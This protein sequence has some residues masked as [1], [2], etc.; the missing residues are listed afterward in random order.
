MVP[1]KA[2]T[3]HAY[4]LSLL[5]VLQFVA[6]VAH[7]QDNLIIN[8]NVASFSDEYTYYTFAEPLKLL[9]ENLRNAIQYMLYNRHVTTI[10]SQD[11]DAYYAPLI[12]SVTTSLQAEYSAP[13]VAKGNAPPV[14]IAVAEP[15]EATYFY[16]VGEGQSPGQLLTFITPTATATLSEPSATA[17]LT[18][19]V[20][21]PTL[22]Y[23]YIASPFNTLQQTISSIL[24]EAV[25]GTKEGEGFFEYTVGFIAELEISL[26]RVDLG[27]VPICYY[28]A[29]VDVNDVYTSPAD[30]VS[31]LG[32]RASTL[33]AQIASVIANG[34]SGSIA[35]LAKGIADKAWSIV[36]SVVSNAKSTA[37]SEARREACSDAR[38][39][40]PAGA[41]IVSENPSG[42]SD[43]TTSKTYNDVLEEAEGLVAGFIGRAADVLAERIVSKLRSMDDTAVAVNITVSVSASVEGDTAASAEYTFSLVFLRVYTP[44]PNTLLT[45]N[46]IDNLK[47]S[48]GARAAVRGEKDHYT[49]IVL[50]L[51]SPISIDKLYDVLRNPDPS[52]GVLAFN[53]ASKFAAILAYRAGLAG[54]P[55]FP[56]C[57][58]DA[59]YTHI[60]GGL[61]EIRNVLEK[62]FV[63]EQRASDT[64]QIIYD[65]GEL[66]RVVRYVNVT[67]LAW[68]ISV[69][70]PNTLEGIAIKASSDA[71]TLLGM[72]PTTPTID[73][74]IVTR[75]YRKYTLSSSVGESGETKQTPYRMIYDVYTTEVTLNSIEEVTKT[76]NTGEYTSLKIK[77]SGS[78]VTVTYENT[79]APQIIDALKT[80]ASPFTKIITGIAKYIIAPVIAPL[81]TIFNILKTSDAFTSLLAA[82]E[83]TSTSSSDT[84]S[85]TLEQLATQLLTNL[86]VEKVEGDGP[87]YYISFR[88]EGS[89]L[90]PPLVAAGAVQNLARILVNNSIVGVLVGPG[91]SAFYYEATRGSTT[92]SS[93]SLDAYRESGVI[94]VGYE[95]W[96]SYTCTVTYE[97]RVGNETETGSVTGYGSSR[98]SGSVSIDIG[99]SA[100]PS[101]LN[102]LEGRLAEAHMIAYKPSYQVDA[103][104]LRV[105]LTFKPTALAQADYDAIYGLTVGWL[106][107]K[108]VYVGP[109]PIAGSGF[110]GYL[111]G[112]I[113]DLGGPS[114][115]NVQDIST[116]VMN[117]LSYLGLPG[118]AAFT[119]PPTMLR[120]GDTDYVLALRG[121]YIGAML[122]EGYRYYAWLYGLTECGFI[123]IAPPQVAV[124]LERVTF[125]C[126]GCLRVEYDPG[127]GLVVYRDAS[128]KQ[129]SLFI[130]TGA[131]KTL[132]VAI[133]TVPPRPVSISLG[134]VAEQQQSSGVSVNTDSESLA[135][136]A[137]SLISNFVGELVEEGLVP[138]VNALAYFAVYRDPATGQLRLALPGSLPSSSFIELKWSGKPQ[139]FV[140]WEPGS[141]EVD[142]MRVAV[143]VRIAPPV[144]YVLPVW[145]PDN[146]VAEVK[147]EV[148]EPGEVKPV[149]LA[150]HVDPATRTLILDQAAVVVH[151]SGDVEY[152]GFLVGRGGYALPGSVASLL[153]QVTHYRVA[154]Y[155]PRTGRVLGVG[156]ELTAAGI[157]K[158]LWVKLDELEPG[159][160]YTALV[161]DAGVYSV[162]TSP[163]CTLYIYKPVFKTWS[164]GRGEY[165]VQVLYT[166]GGDPAYSVARVGPELRTELL[167]SLWQ[168][169][170][171][172]RSTMLHELLSKYSEDIAEKVGELVSTSLLPEDVKK[173]LEASGVTLSIDQEAIRDA[174]VE[175][176]NSGTT[177]NP[178]LKEVDARS[179]AKALYVGD[180]A[181]AF[182][183][184][185][186][187]EC[188]DVNLAD[189]VLD[190]VNV[191]TS[192]LASSISEAAKSMAVSLAADLAKEALS[193]ILPGAGCAA[194]LVVKTAITY[195]ESVK[196]EYGGTPSDFLVRAVVEAG[197]EA[198]KAAAADTACI[199]KSYASGPLNAM[200]DKLVSTLSVPIELGSPGQLPIVS[201]ENGYAPWSVETLDGRTCNLGVCTLKPGTMVYAPSLLGAT[202][203]NTPGALYTLSSVTDTILYTLY[204]LASL[205]QDISPSTYRDIF[206]DKPPL[207]QYREMHSADGLSPVIREIVETLEALDGKDVRLAIKLYVDEAPLYTALLAPRGTGILIDLHD[208]PQG[209][210]VL[211]LGLHIYAPAEFNPRS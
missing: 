191:F 159:V 174:L 171:A 90:F 6:L 158:P 162:C 105:R 203:V 92:R 167:V 97:I 142:V 78:K 127:N 157:A 207:D 26:A 205:I 149:P 183:K 100:A 95:A 160:Y 56:A 85:S 84:I 87:S 175:L 50:V 63:D 93:S 210:I 29:S 112:L 120:G 201:I 23:A 114:M 94:V 89:T 129:Y 179:L 7:A 10:T 46:L 148:V 35:T 133:Y 106:P 80:A 33:Q 36:M 189:L 101:K 24:D 20:D 71:K 154:L 52:Q 13:G 135:D 88:H 170:E 184:G 132:G 30:L 58:E 144:A 123:D 202:Y 192:N 128:V 188:N 65:A 103:A 195:L 73:V 98:V 143:Y 181:E 64:A 83:L 102:F 165:T 9:A 27:A 168:Q 8:E 75:S 49:Y 150:V 177:S 44:P 12:P 53:A 42:S 121:E 176:L 91:D 38:S 110:T 173:K 166:L 107:V 164:V 206:G 5:L 4:I 81:A 209:R 193:S 153:P 194:K 51:P 151:H 155:D 146:R 172:A 178:Y 25:S 136:K 113:N 47:T 131:V 59:R 161:T 34:L 116:R 190:P 82:Y 2:R 37:A 67:G 72:Y 40:V 48:L 108:K 74:V 68:S 199:L 60:V 39:K 104:S 19:P 76:I 186:L 130:G 70:T 61:D 211:R 182:V 77:A 57:G 141:L 180:F 137:F 138:S 99:L 140:A 28:G 139:V 86:E 43:Y 163:V 122:V 11:G 32:S 134:G 145:L 14:A 197:E 16:R 111:A 45:D 109:A 1:S 117:V 54:N 115:S 22:I 79:Q 69:E 31:S 200:I 3:I 17:K 66:Q 62:M 15:S 125:K 185:L 55:G 119:I 96:A 18:I 152:N 187:G 198:V 169:L 118:Y 196:N 156:G 126:S 21:K 147:V 204:S 124:G 41:S 208:A